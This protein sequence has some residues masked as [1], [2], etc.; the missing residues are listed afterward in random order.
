MGE[1]SYCHGDEHSIRYSFGMWTWQF[2]HFGPKGGL[3]RDTLGKRNWMPHEQ[4]KVCPRCGFIFSFFGCDRLHFSECTGK[5]FIDIQNGIAHEA[6]TI[7]P[8]PEVEK[9]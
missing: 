4:P 6:I 9:P 5:R 1:K 8:R 7:E 3:R 2:Q